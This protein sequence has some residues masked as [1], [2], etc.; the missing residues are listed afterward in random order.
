VTNLNFKSK[1]NG[2]EIPLSA[3]FE[4]E[5]RCGRRVAYPNGFK[6]KPKIRMWWNRAA[7]PS[8]G[9]EYFED[10]DFSQSNSET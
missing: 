10:P 2:K 4:P 6:S 5:L 8:F 7:P 3:R 9:F 1:V